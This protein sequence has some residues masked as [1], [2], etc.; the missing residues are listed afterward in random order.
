MDHLLL[1]LDI[2]RFIQKESSTTFKKGDLQFDSERFFLSTLFTAETPFD[3]LTALSKVEGQSTQSLLF[4]FPLIPLKNAGLSGRRKTKTIS[5]T[6]TSQFYS[7]I[8][9]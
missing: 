6:A 5:L 8:C 3:R 9:F 4:C 1:S 2:S 7:N